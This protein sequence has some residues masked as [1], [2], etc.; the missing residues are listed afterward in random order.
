MAFGIVA[1]VFIGVLVSWKLLAFRMSGDFAD[2][3][4][5]GSVSDSLPLDLRGKVWTDAEL[6]TVEVIR[7]SQGS[8]KEQ[9]IQ[10]QIHTGGGHTLSPR[11]YSYQATITDLSTGYR[12]IFGHWRTKGRGWCYAELHPDSARQRVQQRIDTGAWP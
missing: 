1:I 2:A 10:R 9:A 8:G 4:R 12:H 11:Q 3:L 7:L 5:N 6:A